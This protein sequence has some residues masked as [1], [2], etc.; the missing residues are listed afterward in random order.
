MNHDIHL[1]DDCIYVDNVPLVFYHFSNLRV[2][3]HRVYDTGLSSWAPMSTQLQQLIYVPYVQGL[4]ASWRRA[5]ALDKRAQFGTRVGY[6]L[7]P[8]VIF[9]SWRAGQLGWIK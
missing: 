5:H 2:L 6:R 4:K 8:R 7:S 1:E 3:G 9:K